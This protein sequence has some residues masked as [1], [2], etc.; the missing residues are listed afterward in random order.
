MSWS[1][2]SHVVSRR[3]VALAGAS[4]VLALLIAPSLRVSAGPAGTFK[5]IDVP[6]ATGTLLAGI[7][8]DN[9]IAVDYSNGA[10]AQFG[11]LYRNGTFTLL[12]DPSAGTG[13]GQGTS[14]ITPKDT[15]DDKNVLRNTTVIGFFVDSGNMF[16]GFVYHAGSFTTIDD[17]SAGTG[18][19]QG[20][21]AYDMASNGTI[22]GEYIDAIGVTH[23]FLDHNGHFTTVNHPSAGTL[24]G[25]GT[26]LDAVNAN[27]VFVGTYTDSADVTHGFTLHNGTYTTLNDPSAGSA[28]FQGTLT[29]EINRSGVIAGT[30]TDSSNANH[31]MTYKAGVWT[32]LDD[33][34]GTMGT[35][36]Q[37]LNDAGQVVGDY[38]DSTNT[39]HGYL[40]TP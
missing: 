1:W 7:D 12:N 30:Y 35:T 27:G 11:A 17:P 39:Q 26:V 38:H 32:T 28:A 19:L 33:P 31:G 40:Y 37:G 34:N 9:V 29:F 15:G 23:G 4:A 13:L 6:G 20:T 16:H 3:S 36:A 18:S 14:P 10:G 2:S 5:T 24:P 22:L 21:I 25:Q 8:E